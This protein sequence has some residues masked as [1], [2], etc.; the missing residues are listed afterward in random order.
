MI[1]FES[2]KSK[3]DASKRHSCSDSASQRINLAAKQESIN[4]KASDT[5]V[6]ADKRIKRNEEVNDLSQVTFDDLVQPL[7]SYSQ[8]Q[9]NFPS[10]TSPEPQIA[11]IPSLS[12]VPQSIQPLQS[13]QSMQSIQPL[14]PVQSLQSLQ[15]LQSS[16]SFQPS[17]VVPTLE[18]PKR[19]FC[20]STGALG[21]DS[22]LSMNQ[23]TPI[24]ED[25]K[26][27]ADEMNS[28]NDFFMLTKQ[29]VDSMEYILPD[30]MKVDD[31][32]LELHR[33]TVHSMMNEIE[34]ISDI[35]VAGQLDVYKS[36]E[37]CYPSMMDNEDIAFPAPVIG[38][39]DVL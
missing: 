2:K 12:S 29:S 3:S 30:S 33:Q 26:L 38:E 27:K 9:Y 19:D 1:D 17:E 13:M 18:V 20:E 8:P 37:M 25:L 34:N 36:Q 6:Y 4:Q 23:L 14:Q 24:D 7:H 28:M 5:F 15:P 39:G 32:I 21:M 22:L 10:Q 35:L 31:L 16:P 11:Q